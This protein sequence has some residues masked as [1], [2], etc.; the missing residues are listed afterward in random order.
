MRVPTVEPEEDLAVALVEQAGVLAHPGQFFDF[1]RESFLIVSLL[2]GET[3]FADGVDRILRYVALESAAMRDAVAGRRAGVLI[4]LFSCPGTASWGIGDIG[5]LAALTAWLAEGGQRALQ[6][7]P[8]NEM[9]PHEQS[10]Y[11]AVSAMAMNPIYISLASVPD[12]DGE[13][14][15]SSR[16]ARFWRASG[17][18]LRSTTRASGS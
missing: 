6:L 8:I 9:A 7:L 15:L 5:D 17:R 14:S 1:P 12:F 2:P 3:R 10:P 11:S 13:S 4:P 18:R 16:I